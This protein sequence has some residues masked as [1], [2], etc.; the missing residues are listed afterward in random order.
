[1][2]KG[3]KRWSDMDKIQHPA[4]YTQGKV[5]C[6][7]AIESMLGAES[8]AFLRG[9]AVKYIWRMGLKGS[10][11]EDAKKAKW[12]IDRIVSMLGG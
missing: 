7:E 6:I 9:Q 12:Y 1:M 11:L 3:I 10:T 4:H 8:L 5:E 2:S